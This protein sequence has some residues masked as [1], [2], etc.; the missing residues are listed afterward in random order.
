MYKCAVKEQNE[1]VARCKYL[2][3]KEEKT[4]KKIVAMLIAAGVICSLT[5]CNREGAGKNTGPAGGYDPYAQYEDYNER[6]QAI[7]DDTLGEFYTAYEAAKA[8]GDVAQRYA[9]MA[10]AEAKLLEAA[11][12]LPLNSGGG[13]YAIS[14]LAPYTIP[15]VLWGNDAERFHSAL[16]TTLPITAAHRE[17]MKTQWYAVKGSGEYE[18]W[19]RN[20]LKEKGYTL[21]D[22]Y[23]M[24]YTSDPQTWD[25]LATS[26]ASD[27]DAIV[28][29]Y[30][31]LYE[32]DCEGRLQPALAQSYE[33]TEHADGTVS[34]TFHLRQGVKWVDSQ[35]RQVA[36][37]KADDFVAGMQHMLDAGAGLEYLIAGHSAEDSLIVNAYQ[38]Q[39]GALYDFSQVGVRAVDDVTLVYTLTRDVPYFM[40]MLGYSV[41][42]PMS[43]EYYTA[44][45]G[46]FGAEYDD[47]S[48]SYSYGRTPDHIAYCGPY[49]VANNT[50]ENTIV[51]RANPAYWNVKGINIRTLTW[52]Y[53][54]GKDA[55]KGYNDTMSGTIDGAGLNASSI[56]K[57]KA[58]GVFDRL[59]YVGIN[60]A[61]TA[62]AFYN[63]NRQA[64][65][66][67][68][69]PS[70]AV[71]Q[72]NEEQR[73]RAVAAMHNVHFRRA[74]CFG[75]NR[76]A[77]NAQIRGEELRYTAMRNSFTPG[78]FVTLP[79][80]TMV[81]IN[82]NSVIYTAGTAYGQIVQDQLDADGVNI[83]VWDPEAEAG[84]G[85]SDGF[86]GWYDPQ[87][88][89]QELALA[90]LELEQQGVDISA[91]NPIYLDLPYFSGA[92]Q[93]TN[94][95]NA[96]KQ[97]VEQAL[98]G[99]VRINLVACTDMNSV[100]Y[101]GYYIGSG[102]EANY[103][104]YDISG[105]GPDYGDPQTYLDSILPQYA[106]Y[107]TMM[108]GIF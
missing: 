48:T 79:S 8:V 67:F 74:L 83:K 35:G 89:S 40:T 1:T 36:E 46:R 20:Y 12:F 61:T 33:K 100:Y 44:Q 55:L 91:E 6:S 39:S 98:G 31:G 107:L 105:W 68:N 71:S 76:G 82:G 29:T 87:K 64:M 10:I 19:A 28:N 3:G 23:A 41:F 80:K 32:Y 99:A 63:L 21:K 9:L 17:E 37:V 30:D 108:L 97:S 27:A 45:G 104:I 38:Y 58:D 5:A 78:N 60:D 57:A 54:D 77:Y 101:A 14:R 94:R 88:A 51:F 26:R 52:N 84:N 2:R 62:L 69:D 22:S 13:N 7:Y 59:A 86:D 70:G 42:A 18:S 53:N 90:V 103:D 11:V 66:N 24:H 56:E 81:Q 96:Y 85:S 65:S 93:Y 75:A 49:L 15:S 95:A 34:Y 43:R 4:L 16:V 73:Q 50:P 72:K 102:A 25:V 106:G 92:D 47:T